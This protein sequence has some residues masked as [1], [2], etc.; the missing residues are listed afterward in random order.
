MYICAGDNDFAFSYGFVIEVWNCSDS[1]GIFSFSIL[2]LLFKDFISISF[3]YFQIPGNL[4]YNI[5][6][7]SSNPT[8]GEVC[9]IQH[10]VIKF[11]NDLWQVGGFLRVLRFPPPIKN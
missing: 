7:V 6:V 2:Y 3:C 5:M 4:N 11:V 1:V 8:H 9:S 10:Y